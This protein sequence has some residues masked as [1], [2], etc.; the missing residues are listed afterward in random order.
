MLL[1]K[2]REDV[3][4]ANKR[5]LESGLVILTWGNVSAIDRETRLIAIKPSGVPYS[6]MTPTDIVVTDLSGKIIDGDKK[7]S[8]DLLTHL[9]LYN[10]FT[11]IGSVVHT[12]SKWATIWAQMGCSIP[13]LGTTHADDFFGEIPCT[14]DL[15]NEEI[16]NDY[17]KNTGKVIVETINRIDIEKA[18]AVLVKSHGPFVWEKTPEKA[19]DKAM[20]LE[21]VAMMAWHTYM[22]KGNFDSMDNCLMTKHF[23]RK[24]GKNSYYGQKN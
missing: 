22:A 5:L 17:E 4:F 8:S 11:N 6:E 9:E 19:V 7:P 24:H 15:T 1:K 23:E 20:V 13:A 16:N 2:L 10:K 3:C 12:H 18:F 21:Y 14:R